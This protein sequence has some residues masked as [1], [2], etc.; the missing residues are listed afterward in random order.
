[1]A[2]AYINDSLTS[3]RNSSDKISSLPFRRTN[4]LPQ[5]ALAPQSWFEAHL[6]RDAA[7]HE[8]ALFRATPPRF[9][10][11]TAGRQ[12]GG[13]KGEEW[14]ATKR[15]GPRRAAQGS[16]LR[17]SPLKE[18]RNAP[19]QDPRRALVAASKLLDI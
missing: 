17:A 6:I 7:P 10:T 9:D 12:A 4:V 2:S 5:A 18:K 13:G 15:V 19:G 3:M 1:M 16:E 11:V 8:R 14:T